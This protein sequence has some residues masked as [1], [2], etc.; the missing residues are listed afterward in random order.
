MKAKIGADDVAIAGQGN[1]II[2]KVQVRDLILSAQTAYKVN[3]KLGLADEPFDVWRKAALHD[4][5]GRQSYR[6]VRQAEFGKTLHYFL[7][8]AGKK[9]GTRRAAAKP[10][11][12]DEAG[13]ARWSL[14]KECQEQAETF[15]SYDGARMYAETLLQKIH[16]TTYDEATAKQ[17]WQVMFTLRNR[18]RAK[19][20]SEGF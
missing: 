3:E 14:D 11:G 15:G 1:Q 9:P 5:C 19:K 10:P 16:K 17:L 18:A 20:R 13:R 4:A 6:D 7:V 8:L 12:A 2:S